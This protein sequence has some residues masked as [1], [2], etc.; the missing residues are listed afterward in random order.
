VISR[1]HATAP[2]SSAPRRNEDDVLTFDGPRS[3]IDLWSDEVLSDPFEAY[4]ELR[5]LG[6]A[7]WLD[8][9]DI[10]AV[11]R[12]A[13][14][15]D[16]LSNWKAFSSASGTGIDPES[17]R[18]LANTGTLG[19]DP[20]EHTALRRRTAAELSHRHVDAQKERI[21]RIAETTIEPYLCGDAFDAVAGV[22]KPFVADVIGEL[23]GLPAQVVADLPDKAATAFDLFGPTH[24]RRR[25]GIQA[26]EEILG[27]AV[28]L[29]ASAD[30]PSPPTGP[31]DEIDRLTSYMFPGVDTTVQA[32][33][34][35]LYCFARWPDQW[36]LLREN[37]SLISS[38]IAEVLRL[39]S[40]VRFFTRLCTTSVKV[41]SATI[42]P[43]TRVLVMYGSA[44]RDERRFDD[45]DVFR[46]TRPAQQHL[47]FGHGPHRCEGANLA[48]VELATFLEVLLRQV[49]RI[50]MHEPPTWGAGFAIHGLERLQVSFVSETD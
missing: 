46:I 29:T 42:G 24:D 20:P 27:R 33:S 6:P 49:A 2:T 26:F 40:P 13:E 3:S 4:A 19:T 8:R 41:G 28:E 1:R 44:N 21:R 18:G 31:G 23:V 22:S 25:A 50:T 5:G 9:Y 14:V 45:P 34:S 15:R 39:H 48:Q 38:A 35:A 30:W 37:P 36:A 12:F 43:D 7:V 16:T 17:N 47:A 32:V 11:T 10:V